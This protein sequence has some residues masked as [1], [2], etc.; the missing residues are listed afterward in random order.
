MTDKQ[1]EL[2]RELRAQGV[3]YIRIAS[4]IGLS[5]NTVKSFC[6]NHSQHGSTYYTE[7]GPHSVSGS[8]RKVF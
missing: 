6:Q 3:G 1:R 5:P 2:I 8:K 7:S 4:A